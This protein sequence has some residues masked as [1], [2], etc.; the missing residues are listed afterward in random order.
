MDHITAFDE[1]VGSWFAAHRDPVGIGIMRDITSLGGYTVLTVIVLFTL[2][3]LLVFHRRL[4]A[5]FV[6]LAVVGGGLIAQLTKELIGR[7]R[8]E[9]ADPLLQGILPKNPSF[10]SGHSMLSAVVYLTLALL[11]AGRVRGRRIHLYL[12]GWSLLLTFLIGVSRLY[13][14][15][16]YFS[17]VAGGWSFGLLW[18][19]ACRW[20]E[21]HWMAVRERAV[22]VEEGDGGAPMV[23]A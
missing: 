4:T 1:R 22:T 2:G 17:D 7:P 20:V 13:L 19:L 8:P 18:A 11:V 9:L 3:M 10:P 15:V 6:L 23:S 12:I 21:D 16:H 5:F 14:G